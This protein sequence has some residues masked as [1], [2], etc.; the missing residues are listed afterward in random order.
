MRKAMM[1]VAV[2]LGLVAAPANAMTVADFL[3]K[4]T[5]LK[6][7]GPIAMLSADI[8][9]LKQEIDTASAAYHADLAAAAA[10]GKRPRS[11]PPPKGQVKM[12]SDELIAEFERIP[13]AKR[14]VSV[15]A[16]FAAMMHRRYPCR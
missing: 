13:P 3:A 12:G 8:G 9:L 1:A 10:A 2:G 15:S 4:V 5:A 6:A 14:N 16:A 11:C 7:K